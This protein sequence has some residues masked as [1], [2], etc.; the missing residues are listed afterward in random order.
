MSALPVLTIASCANEKFSVGL[1][2]AVISCLAQSSGKYHY[3]LIIMDGGL[4]KKTIN[5]LTQ[6]IDSTAKK[7][8]TPYTLRFIVPEQELINQLP[9]RAGTWMTYA[10]FLLPKMLS[11]ES[12]IYLDSDILCLRGVEDFLDAWDGSSAL[13]AVRDPMRFLSMDWPV[14]H[15]KPGKDEPYFNAGL[16]L[17]NLD[18]MRSHLSLTQVRQCIDK[19]GMDNLPFHDQTIL[20]YVARGQIIEIGLLNNLVLQTE[21]TAKVP[22]VWQNA[23]MHYIGRVKPWLR[24]ESEVKRYF[25]EVLYYHAS[26]VYGIEGVSPRVITNQNRKQTFRKAKIYPW[27]KPQ[28]GKIYKDIVASLEKMDALEPQL[29]SSDFFR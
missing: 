8:N 11:E 23:N 12:V 21:F 20:N 5:D 3:N 15:E 13:V 29:K 25:S 14:K 1:S 10:R 17:M 24:D 4:S 6:K 26:L 27:I 28:R 2:I 9:E 22:E 19:L 16:I 18:W 7:V